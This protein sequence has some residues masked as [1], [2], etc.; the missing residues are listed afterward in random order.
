MEEE[1]HYNEIA[2]SGVSVRS[3]TVSSPI[4]YNP[5]PSSS[6]PLS[7]GVNLVG[8]TSRD[9]FSTPGGPA[10]ASMGRCYACGQATYPTLP[11][12]PSGVTV[13]PTPLVPCPSVGGF[14]PVSSSPPAPPIAVSIMLKKC[15][16]F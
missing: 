13:A 10:G 3:R 8:S 11:L 9:S 16:T 14:L 6:R 5:S 12:G 7:P 4:P 1:R 2:M 15:T